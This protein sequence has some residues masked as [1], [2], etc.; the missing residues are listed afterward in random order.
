MEIGKVIIPNAPHIQID[1]RREE[2][3]PD[4]PNFKDFLQNPDVTI[5]NKSEDIR[6]G[7]TIIDEA[8]DNK[9]ILNQFRTTYNLL[10]GYK[11]SF[12]EEINL[13]LGENGRTYMV[14]FN[15]DVPSKNEMLARIIPESFKKRILGWA[16]NYK[17]YVVVE[18][19]N[20]EFSIEHKRQIQNIYLNDTK[21]VI[22]YAF[23]DVHWAQ[24]IDDVRESIRNTEMNYYDK[25]LITLKQKIVKIGETATHR[26]RLEVLS[27]VN[28]YI[29]EFAKNYYTGS[30]PVNDHSMSRLKQLVEFINKQ[31]SLH[32][33]IV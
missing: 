17:L 22:A 11:D 33:E 18:T 27:Q 6:N 26:E 30:F 9:I 12:L 32:L 19:L 20:P 15:E 28:K 21:Q 5:I 10:L 31:H 24:V 29:A 4:R 13:M 8:N 23:H 2:R 14:S 25:K 7:V 3:D 1:S 16:L